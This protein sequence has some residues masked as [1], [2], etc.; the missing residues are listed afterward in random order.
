[1]LM[2]EVRIFKIRFGAFVGD[3]GSF[4]K[5]CTFRPMFNLLAKRQLG[6]LFSTRM[7]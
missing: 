4:C 3:G 2:M 6:C 7:L 5:D 1:M